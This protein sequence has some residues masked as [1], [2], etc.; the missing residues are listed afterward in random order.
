MMV[1]L[2]S[3]GH[4]VATDQVDQVVLEKHGARLLQ[5]I[6]I[7]SY[8]LE[9]RSKQ[10]FLLLTMTICIVLYSWQNLSR[11]RLQ[12]AYRNLQKA[13]KIY[14]SSLDMYKLYHFL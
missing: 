7:V 14:Q 11:V 2:V 12:K 13:T 9:A 5:N 4:R 8:F 1:V 10:H 3:Q 6:N